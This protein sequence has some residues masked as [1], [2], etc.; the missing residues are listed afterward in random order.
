MLGNSIRTIVRRRRPSSSHVVR[1]PARSRRRVRVSDGVGVTTSRIR[2]CSGFHPSS[3]TRLATRLRRPSSV[4]VVVAESES[5]WPHRDTER[6]WVFSPIVYL[7][8]H[9]RP[10]FC[11]PSPSSVTVVLRLSSVA[12]C[13]L[14]VPRSRDETKSETESESSGR[15]ENTERFWVFSTDRKLELRPS[16]SRRSL[17][18]T[19]NHR[20]NLVLV[21]L[22]TAVASRFAP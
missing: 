20:H 19:S 5:E 2:F 17:P 7:N 13:S 10:S 16:S 15:I 14:P 6:F 4:A 9:R 22:I 3:R 8:L 11:H 18:S 21:N 12:R 1:R